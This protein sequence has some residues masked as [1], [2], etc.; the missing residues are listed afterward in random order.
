VHNTAIGLFEPKGELVD[1]R[2]YA[3]RTLDADYALGPLEN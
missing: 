3:L 1:T 2:S